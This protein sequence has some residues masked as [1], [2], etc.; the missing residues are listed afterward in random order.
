[1]VW[2]SEPLPE[3]IHVATIG[4]D[5]IFIHAQY[6]NGYLLD[7]ATGKI[8]ATLTEGYKCSRF[9]LSG[10]SLLGPSMDVLDV[11]NPDA[12]RLVSSGPRLDPSECIGACAS[13]R[14][15]FYTG[16]GADFKSA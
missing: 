10:S 16:H 2:Q 8:R 13:N 1:M 11:S 9:T 7:K 12:I 5:F 15:I 14:R 3:A 6:K 4:P